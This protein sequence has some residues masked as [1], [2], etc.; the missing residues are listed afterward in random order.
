VTPRPRSASLPA[1]PSSTRPDRSGPERDLR[2]IRRA[3]EVLA[4]AR[5]IEDAVPH[6]LE[7]VG[8]GPGWA[9]GALFVVDE[10]A[11]C[12][13]P[14]GAW[15]SRDALLDPFFEVTWRRTFRR[16]EGL[17]GLAWERARAV[18]CRD[19]GRD[20][21]YPRR[22]EA[23]KA[24]LAGAVFQP[25]TAGGRVVG[26]LELYAQAPLERDRAFL[27]RLQALAGI[28]GQFVERAMAEAAVRDRERRFRA[29]VAAS[30]EAIVFMDERGVVTGWNPQAE[31]T[32]G[33]SAAE[34]VGQAFDTL[35]VPEELRTPHRAGLE[36]YLR[37][38]EPRVLGRRLEMPAVHRDGRRLTVELSIVADEED[39]RVSFIGSLRDISERIADQAELRTLAR[40]PEERPSP[41]LRI[42]PTGAVLYANAAAG[43]LVH[44]GRAGHRRLR[45]AVARS[46]FDGTRRVLQIELAGASY[47]ISVEPVPDEGYARVYGLDISERVRA[48]RE[49]RRN[50]ADIRALYRIATDTSRGLRARVRELLALMA[51]RFGMGTGVLSR[52]VPGGLEVVEVN[53]WDRRFGPGDVIPL[54]E[55]FSAVTIE[56][57]DVLVI[58]DA[59]LLPWRER[60]AHHAQGLASYIGIPVEVEG[61]IHGVLSFSSPH[62]RD[63]GFKESDIDFLRLMARW[64]GGELERDRIAR[65]L[66]DANRGL[67]EA[68][69]RARDLAEAAT[70]ASAAKSEFLAAMSHEI[71]T[72]LHGI[73]GSL[74]VL[75]ARVSDDDSLGFVETLGAAAQDLR[76][77]V[78]DVLDFSRVEA[79]QLTLEPRPVELRRVLQDVAELQ[80][81]RHRTDVRLHWNVDD[82][83]PARVIADP[84]RIRQIVVNLVANAMKFTPSGHVSVRASCPADGMDARLLRLEVTDTGIGMDRETMERAYDAFYQADASTSR[85]YG[86]AGLGLA[87]TRRLV[88]LMDGTIEI[89]SRLGAGTRVTV[90]LPVA[91]AGTAPEAQPRVVRERARAPLEPAHAARVL[92]VDDDRVS[93]AVAREILLSLG[94][95]VDTAASADEGLRLM[96]GLEH[97]LVLLDCRLPQI[98]GFEVARRHRRFEAEARRLP[99]P[100]VAITADAYPA[101]R[102]ACL[103]A[104]MSD[105]LPKPYRTADLAGVLERWL[106][107]FVAPPVL[108]SPVRQDGDALGVP[109]GALQDALDGGGAARVL[110]LAGL[111]IGSL[112]DGTAA[113]TRALRDG[114]RHEARE[115]AHRLRGA[116]AAVGEDILADA[117]ARVEAAA[118][119][120]GGDV[121]RLTDEV[122]AA[123]R[124]AR[125]RMDELAARLTSAEG[126]GS[127]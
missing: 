9:A 109:A 4:A 14:V 1:R 115:V 29:V 80:A 37:T 86:G 38:R 98:D 56:R 73:I 12:L 112:A 8:A 59:S 72:P 27:A 22:A 2:R 91:D 61:E 111:F 82:D 5:D 11:A 101:T 117:L 106:D 102:R 42:D 25:L 36:R 67:E 97:D 49:L 94:C 79:R 105:H 45:E 33:W 85:R 64:I 13:R 53:A 87:I 35:A 96:G 74:E 92:V 123:G 113:L 99:V 122:E 7:L 47:S 83:V 121:A 75:R 32:F 71:R 95:Q 77:I 84:T 120:P 69:A 104:G 54:A 114:R 46:L 19:V 78:D 6:L 16:G 116:A 20:R 31:A 40:F 26:V 34:A 63:E 43:P 41:V 90:A 89:S 81:L 88:D 15:A 110:E 58:P 44:A 100:I 68:A 57:R 107:A 66:K 108:G 17:P 119:T 118:D 28:L 125:D 51:D 24:G 3:L 18:W 65:A 103:E 55:T 126:G 93:L 124:Q 50:E 23:A 10:E 48:E 127:T 60:P 62:V 76:R 52:R 39:G 70:A 21:R 30:L